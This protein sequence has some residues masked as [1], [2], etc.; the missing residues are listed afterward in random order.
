[1]TGLYYLNVTAH[2]LAAVV[3]LGGMFFIALVGAPV[4]RRIESASAR[5][6]LLRVL[7]GRFRS[8]AWAAIAV[9]LMTG[10]ANLGF[11]SQLGWDTLGSPA[12]WD[13]RYGTV[14]GW[15]LAAVAVMIVVSAL[16]DFVLGPMASRDE[17][18][19]PEAV[20]ARRAA[21]WLG[22]ANAVVGILVVYLAVRLARGG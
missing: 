17:P 10:V 6:E 2:V 12:F 3:W 1:M 19:S 18:R 13:T 16:H 21:A 15:K 22:R 5:T 11:R 20:R 14:L 7:G 9:L 4:L 8:I